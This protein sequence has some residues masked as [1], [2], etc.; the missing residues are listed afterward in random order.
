M[1][2]DAEN[3]SNISGLLVQSIGSWTPEERLDGFDGHALLEIEGER[4]RVFVKCP[5]LLML[6]IGLLFGVYD[7]LFVAEPFDE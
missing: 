4:P 6:E 3:A 2:I 7:G 1:L 5:E